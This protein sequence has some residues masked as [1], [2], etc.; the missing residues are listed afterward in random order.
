M[1]SGLSD[2]SLVTDDEKNTNS[3]CL[4]LSS[5]RSHHLLRDEERGNEEGWGNVHIKNNSYQMC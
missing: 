2:G 4:F 5:A 3:V 1:R